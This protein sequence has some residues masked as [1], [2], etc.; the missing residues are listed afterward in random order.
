MK[1]PFWKTLL[2]NLLGLLLTLVMLPFLGLTVV[3]HLADRICQTVSRWER[4]LHRNQGY[5]TWE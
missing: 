1:R 5:H 4:K 2:L 3:G